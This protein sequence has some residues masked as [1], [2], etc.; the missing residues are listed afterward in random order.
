MDHCDECS[1]Q[2][3]CSL[4]ITNYG[5]VDND[6]TKC[7]S[8]DDKYYYD[9]SLSTFKLCSNKMANCELCSTDG[10][11]ACKKC[12]NNYAFKHTNTLECAQK[13][14]LEGDT[15]FFSNDTGV[16][17]YSC[18]LYGL[19]EHCDKCSNKD[20]CDSCITGYELYNV[21]K[22]CALHREI[23][24][25]IYIFTN[26]GLL[27]PCSAL[28]QD[29]QRCN[30]SSTCLECQGDSALIDNNTCAN[31]TEIEENKNYFKD[32][33]TNMYISCSVMD[34]CVTCASSTD[35]TS[36]K[37]GFTLNNKKCVNNNENGKN[38]NDDGLS[39]GAIIGIVFGC[40]GF[41]LII[42]GIGY[43]VFNK[44]FKRDN[45][46]VKPDINEKVEIKVE[47]FENN[48]EIDDK[49]LENVK[50]NAVVVHSTKRSIHNG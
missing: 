50:Q 13:T 6:H 8:I 25:N 31:K 10:E 3:H 2:N 32:E 18:S 28:I 22:L 36:C 7:E 16:N 48:P 29:C 39:T 30:D 26:D 9:T 41:L 23:E 40:L 5:I 34:N 4:C 12:F 24:N 19:I 14:S 11:Y 49:E 37:N 15:H 46:I 20:T 44:F 21:N 45:N 1:A 33:K 43:F 47:K 35:C 42:S 17:Y 27:T 38:D